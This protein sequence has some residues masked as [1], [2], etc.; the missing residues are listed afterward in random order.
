M[1]IDAGSIT[2]ATSKRG[3]FN[4]RIN[5]YARMPKRSLG[6]GSTAASIIVFAVLTSSIAAT[7]SGNFFNNTAPNSGNIV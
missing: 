6:S 5:H 7:A 3:C 4:N 2:L 1:S